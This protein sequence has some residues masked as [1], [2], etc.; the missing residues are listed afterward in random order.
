M[1][2]LDI[3]D[4]LP[5]D[6]PAKQAVDINPEMLLQ[7]ATGLEEPLDIAQRYGF[8][9]EEFAA[10][11][12]WPPWQAALEAKRTELQ[13]TGVTLRIKSAFMAEDVLQRA[14]LAVCGHDATLPQK[15]DFIRL[16]A[17]LGDVEPKP[18]FNA[19][20]QGNGF[21]ISINFSSPPPVPQSRPAAP[22]TIDHD[23]AVLPA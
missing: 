20:A 3:L 5:H 17:K 22:L 6:P 11:S 15:M 18:N 1:A 23:S 13:Q 7:I 8:N 10:L 19:A 9:E 16:A 2:V 21:S 4:I 14:Y 12:N